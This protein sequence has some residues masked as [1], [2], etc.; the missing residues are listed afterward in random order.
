MSNSCSSPY[1]YASLF[2]CC[3]EA[4]LNLIP[5]SQQSIEKNKDDMSLNN[6]MLKLLAILK[7]QQTPASQGACQNL[8]SPSQHPPA[9]ANELLLLQA[10]LTKSRINSNSVIPANSTGTSQALNGQPTNNGV[11]HQQQYVILNN[12]LLKL[13]AMLK[14][15]QTPA[16]QGAYQSPVSPSQHPPAPA[17]ELL[18]GS[19][20]DNAASVAQALLSKSDI[21]SNSAI[22]LNGQP[23]NNGVTHQQQQLLAL[24]NTLSSMSTKTAEEFAGYGCVQQQESLPQIQVYID[25]FALRF[26]SMKMIIRDSSSLL[27]PLVFIRRFNLMAMALCISTTKDRFR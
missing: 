13:L 21:N 9:P 15:Q 5:L 7:Q 2:L 20:N 26:F 22:P 16:S 25:L 10:F 12:E 6:E 19:Q 17:N 24:L 23:T 3:D 1:L 14:Q 27:S 8:V 4:S 18:L 11:T